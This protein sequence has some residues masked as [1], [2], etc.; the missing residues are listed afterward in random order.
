MAGEVTVSVVIPAFNEA[1]NLAPVV[2]E[3]LGVLRREPSIDSFEVL[4]IDDGSRDGTAEAADALAAA[5]TEVRVFHHPINRGFG[6]ALRTGFTASRGRY[7]S[8]VSADG[9]VNPNDV[10]DLLA[11]IGDADLIIGRRERDVSGSREVIT[12]CMNVLM[13]VVLGFVPENTGIYLVRGELLRRMDLRSDTGL[14]N[15]E[16]RTYCREWGCRIVWGVTRFRPRLS[17]E[18]K[19]TNLRTMMQTF[20]E[21]VKLGR[22]IR[23]RTRAGGA[24]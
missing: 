5:N 3:T 13:R 8:L 15:L 9:E 22:A 17:G 6:A 1:A 23:R 16:V 24:A 7:V 19:V 4:V 2:N 12:F 21:M 14:A 20:W 11:N 10:V 18:S